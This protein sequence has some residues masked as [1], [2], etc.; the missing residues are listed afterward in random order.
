[1]PLTTKLVAQPAS[2]SPQAEIQTSTSASSPMPLP[3]NIENEVDPED[4]QV[5]HFGLV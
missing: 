3:K 4:I 5:V 2:V 1:M